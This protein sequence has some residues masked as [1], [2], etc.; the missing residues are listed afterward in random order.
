M[1]D[2]IYV[3][4]G[5]T[6][7]YSDRTEWTVFYANTEE[8]AQYW[9]RLLTKQAL[10]VESLITNELDGYYDRWSNEDRKKVEALTSDPDFER[11]YSETTYFY[12][13]VTLIPE[14][15]SEQ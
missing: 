7:E 15:S 4:H 12:S 3:I 11:F 1:S 13:E 5:T 8:D 6:G 9:V 14:T 10:E 2:T